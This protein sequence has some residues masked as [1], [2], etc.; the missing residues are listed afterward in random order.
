MP[1]VYHI[2][3]E[4]KTPT[5]TMNSSQFG[6]EAFDDSDEDKLISTFETME[7]L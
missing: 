1:E 6:F 7:A 2:Q 4:A 5:S 3:P